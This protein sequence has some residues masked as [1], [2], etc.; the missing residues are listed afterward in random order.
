MNDLFYVVIGAAV[1]FAGF[2]A[3]FAFQVY[4]GLHSSLT[5]ARVGDI[6]NFEY[7][8]PYHGE[9]ERILAR[10]IEPVHT[11]DEYQI[12]QLNARSNYRRNDPNFKR[13]KH[14][15]TCEMSDGTVRNF[16]AERTRN[17][18]KLPANSLFRAVAA[19]VL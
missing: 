15:V 12:R 2:L 3:V 9:P 14:L 5:S 17:V 16:Y 11:L 19:L 13:T 1:L 6:F 10:V 8:Q 4:N 18:R 7:E